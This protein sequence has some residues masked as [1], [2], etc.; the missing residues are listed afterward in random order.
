[1]SRREGENGLVTEV[2]KDLASFDRLSSEWDGLLERS[3]Q[4]VYFL[5]YDWNRLWWRHFAPRGSRLHIITC[6]DQAGRL[7]GIAPFYWREH[8]FLGL[9]S[10]RELLFLGMGIELK[11]SEFL[12]VIASRGDESRVAAAI[13]TH[14]NGS[15]DWDRLWLHQVPADSSALPHLVSCLGYETASPTICDHAPY[16][17]TSVGWDTFKRNLGRSMR[18]NVEYYGRRLQRKYSCQFA[19]VRTQAE[20]DAAMDALVRLHQARW[21]S[22]GQLGAFS[23]GQTEVFLRQAMSQ[24]LAAGRLRFWTL[25][26]DGQVEAAL[27]GFLDNGVLH[28]FQKGFNPAY[29]GDDLGTAMLGLCLRECFDDGQVQVF[30]FMGGGAPYKSLWARQSRDTSTYMVCRGTLRSQLFDARE[31]SVN[32]LRVAFRKLMPLPLRAARRDMLQKWRMRK[33]RNPRRS[34]RAQIFLLAFALATALDV[35]LL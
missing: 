4:Q 7:L 2:Y 29:A 22:V 13:A 8:S 21:T 11:T 30:D 27:M 1:V 31:Q 15:D 19:V 6:R 14:L 26:I 28:Y 34:A 32:A 23:G 9:P 10:A 12:D 17:D 24:S 20:L 33:H 35:T 3:A 5:R 16:I 18:R 25:A